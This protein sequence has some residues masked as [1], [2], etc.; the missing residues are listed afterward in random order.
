MQDLVHRVLDLQPDRFASRRCRSLASEL[1][2]VLQGGRMTRVDR[3]AL[4]LIGLLVGQHESRP[5]R[6]LGADGARSSAG[7]NHVSERGLVIQSWA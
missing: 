3:N 4:E 2:L 6:V 5:G 1:L 7:T